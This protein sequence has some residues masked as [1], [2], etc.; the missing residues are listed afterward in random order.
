MPPLAVKVARLV[1]DDSPE[2]IMDFA[3]APNPEGIMARQTKDSPRTAA[4]EILAKLMTT[5]TTSSFCGGCASFQ[6][7]PPPPPPAV[8]AGTPAVR[9]KRK[10]S[11][12]AAS[13]KHATVSAVAA[14]GA[15]IE[16]AAADAE[17]AAPDAKRT[18]VPVDSLITISGFDMFNSYR[19]ASRHVFGVDLAEWFRDV[20]LPYCAERKCALIP[21]ELRMRPS[22]TVATSGKVGVPS[23][24]LWIAVQRRVAQDVRKRLSTRP[25]L[26]MSQ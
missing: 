2:S 21:T 10:A 8:V 1:Y 26:L 6:P 11:S 22:K 5:T 14:A 17:D 19:E 16:A 4:A 3:R 20:Q 15:A 12:A 24:R 23:A 13:P 18:S 7:P 9:R 25:A